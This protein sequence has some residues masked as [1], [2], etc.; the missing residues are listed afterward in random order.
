[1]TRDPF[2]DILRLCESWWAKMADSTKTGQ[3]EF[4]ENFLAKLGWTDFEPVQTK[5]HWASLVSASYILRAGAEVAAHFVMPGC[6]EP[7]SSIME[8]GLD[9]CKTTRLLVGGT[10]GLNVPYALITDLQRFYFYDVRGDALLLH[11]DAPVHYKRDFG[12]VLHREDVERGAIEEIRRQ[13]PGFVARQLREWCNRWTK[14]L[15]DKNPQIAEDAVDLALDRFLVMGFLLYHNIL[16]RPSFD[17][18]KRLGGLAA[19]A[20]SDRPEGCGR[21]LAE[22]FDALWHQW[23][24]GLFAPVPHLEEALTQDA[25]A[26]PLLKEFA[27]LSRTKFTIATI[28]ESF[29]YGSEAAEKARVRMVP[30]ENA[31]RETALAKLNLDTVDS[32]QIEIDVKGEGY[33]AIFHWFDKLVAL[34]ERLDSDYRAREAREVDTSDLDLLAWAERDSARPRALVDKR[35]HAAQQGL[36]VYYDSPRQFRTARLMLYLHIIS[37]YHQTKEHFAQFPVIEDTLQPRPRTIE[38]DRKWMSESASEETEV[39]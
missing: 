9:F 18:P 24:A 12:T 17:F 33:R 38:S 13:P 37:R 22:L 28:L 35:Q 19:L 34:Y 27:L 7:P 32:A 11:A 31:D 26:T 29:N 25:F 5:A 6:L 3:N 14:E 36:I 21:Q 20:L 23:H 39:G 10:R 16:K 1:M 8:R 2:E 30:D 4:A 15:S